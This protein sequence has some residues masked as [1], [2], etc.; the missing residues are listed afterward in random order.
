M[1]F[2]LSP[3]FIFTLVFKPCV[4]FL[5]IYVAIFHKMLPLF[6]FEPTVDRSATATKSD[7]ASKKWVYSAVKHNFR[8]FSKLT[9]YKFNFFILFS[10]KNHS[11]RL[12]YWS[13]IENN[14][15]VLSKRGS[16]YK[17]SKIT[18]FEFYWIW[19]WLR[20]IEILCIS[21][22][23]EISTF[24][25]GAKEVQNFKLKVHSGP[26][27]SRGLDSDDNAD[28]FHKNHLWYVSIWSL[29]VINV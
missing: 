23:A 19:D 21:I 25:G 6:S 13:A 18:H 5:L 20:W 27:G 7:F 8:Q 3:I 17:I 9:S 1:F 29:V 11:K 26:E 28:N 15:K 2:D 4:T 12:Y 10:L 22:S 14:V 16:L 24:T